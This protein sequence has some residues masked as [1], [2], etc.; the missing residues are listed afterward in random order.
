MYVY[1]YLSALYH[2]I[3]RGQWRSIL[4]IRAQRRYQYIVARL[5]LLDPPA[6]LAD[7]VAQLGAVGQQDAPLQVQVL[8]LHFLLRSSFLHRL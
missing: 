8:L 6:A 5:Q 2:K 3:R 1:S 7:H 4:W